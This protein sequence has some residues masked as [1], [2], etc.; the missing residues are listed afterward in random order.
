MTTP[1]EH[2]IEA[3]ELL[4]LPRASS[5][6]W[7]PTAAKIGLGQLRRIE[8]EIDALRSVLVGVLKTEAGRDTKATLVRA[9]GMSSAE[10]SKTE[11]VAD[12]VA[13]V[14]GAL[15]AL[16]DGS[17]TGEHLRRLTPITDTA[18]AEELL[19]VAASQR[20]DD[21]AKTVDQWRIDRNAKGWR[22]RQHNARSL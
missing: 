11:Q 19:I 2:Q 12:I 3:L 7:D 15:D 10:A 8:G 14:P 17:V 18:E 4:C 9:F 22:D 20:A 1:V 16:A 13:R 21:F 6:G 5:V